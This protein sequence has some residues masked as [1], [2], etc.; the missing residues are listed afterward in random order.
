MPPDIAYH[1]WLV[2][3]SQSTT[4]QIRPNLHLKSWPPLERWAIDLW[5]LTTAVNSCA[6]TNDLWNMLTSRWQLRAFF[7]R[8]TEP[9]DLDNLQ[10]EESGL[11]QECRLLRLQLASCRQ[12]QWYS[13]ITVVQKQ[14]KIDQNTVKKLSPN[15]PG[16]QLTTR[17]HTDQPK[18]GHRKRFN[19][20]N[21]ST[22]NSNSKCPLY[23]SSRLYEKILSQGAYT[24]E[25]S[26]HQSID[27]SID[28][29]WILLISILSTLVTFLR[30]LVLETCHTWKLCN[31]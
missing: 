25:G 16:T 26:N 31:H 29:V 14:S 18:L 15:S 24:D 28:T 3:Q 10:K 20:K 2:G 21:H 12:K 5:P 8:N 9:H 19:F 11:K 7:S 13:D 17:T 1:L 30:D 4:F 23:S 22:Q 6:A 27:Q